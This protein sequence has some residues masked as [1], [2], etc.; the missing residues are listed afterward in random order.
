MDS[1]QDG[2]NFPG[3]D[4]DVLNLD[5]NAEFN[6]SE[7]VDDAEDDDPMDAPAA[8]KASGSKPE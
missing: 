4:E 6:D 7:D 5:D 3:K 2:A 8:K 1:E